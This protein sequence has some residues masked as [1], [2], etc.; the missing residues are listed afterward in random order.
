MSI[1]GADKIE[2]TFSRGQQYGFANFEKKVRNQRYESYLSIDTLFCVGL[3]V[4][5]PQACE[6]GCFPPK[7]VKAEPFSKALKFCLASFFF[8]ML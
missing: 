6:V 3:I 1:L 2:L 4:W 5:I 7:M 8:K